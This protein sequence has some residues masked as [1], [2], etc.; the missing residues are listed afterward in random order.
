MPIRVVMFDIGG[1]LLTNAW[2][3]AQRASVLA[4]Y[5]LAA[6]DFEARHDTF[7]D[8]LETGRLSLDEYLERVVVDA[9]RAFSRVQFEEAMRA[10]S[11]ELPGMLDFVRALGRRGSRGA[12]GTDG[13]LV[14]DFLLCTLNNESR[15]LNRY[16][17][18][19]FGLREPFRAF[20]S[21]CYLGVAKPDPAIDRAALD[22]T[23]AEPGECVLVDDRAVNVEAA[24]ALGLHAIHHRTLAET[25]VA[26]AALGLP[27]PPEA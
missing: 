11:R 16:R 14:S 2:D 22:L 6:A 8:D 3:G 1:V 25:R 23:Q 17:I 13:G 15:E 7:V 19:T 24:Q 20:F 18:D 4:E 12:A 26:L 27:V 10:Q 5:G 9:P 21:S